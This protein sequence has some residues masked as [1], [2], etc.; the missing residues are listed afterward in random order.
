[1]KLSGTLASANYTAGVLL[2]I[3]QS[4]TSIGEVRSPLG[5]TTVSRIHVAINGNSGNAT[6][7]LYAF[8][9][10]ATSLTSAQLQ[11]S[12]IYYNNAV[13]IAGAGSVEINSTGSPIPVSMSGNSLYLYYVANAADAATDLIADIYFG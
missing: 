4:N 13:A 7:A 6:I 10:G 8:T 1:M 3:P 5:T 2:E 12:E 11:S 9:P